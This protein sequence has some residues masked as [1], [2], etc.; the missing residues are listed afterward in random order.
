M[1]TGNGYCVLLLTLVIL[2]LIF[3]ILIVTILPAAVARAVRV[4]GFC[5]AALTSV[6]CA[7]VR[8]FFAFDCSLRSM[9]TMRQGLMSICGSG[10]GSFF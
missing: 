2:S 7:F 5:P 4:C 6:V 3:F 8:A 10:V 1:I 9:P